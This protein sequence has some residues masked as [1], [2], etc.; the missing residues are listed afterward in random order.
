MPS[1]PRPV[2]AKRVLR[3][4]ARIDLALE[5]DDLAGRYDIRQSM[6]LDLKHGEVIVAQTDPPP[7]KSQIGRK[8]E[9]SVVHRDIVTAEITRWGWTASFLSLDNNYIL[10]PG[11]P[12]AEAV[13][14]IV[15]SPPDRPVLTRSNIRQAYRLD[16]TRRGDITVTIHPRPAPV[17][18][19]NF[20]ADGL[21]LATSA[22]PHYTLGQELSFKLAFPSESDLPV[23]LIEGQAKIVRLAFSQDERTVNLGLKFQSLKSEAKWALPKILN[24]Y[25]LE[26]QRNRRWGELVD[27]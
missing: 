26:E 16:T 2:E 8:L 11:E 27:F 19:V 7:L 4:Q 21:M 1:T 13:P 20:S 12:A 6:I 17:R 23:H 9:A 24:Y 22:P 5:L 15:L 18:L 14:V 25:M 3:P 10:N